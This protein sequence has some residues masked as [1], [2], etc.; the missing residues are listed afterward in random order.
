[1][2]LSYPLIALALLALETTSL[3]CFGNSRCVIN[4]GETK[5][6]TCVGGECI[7]CDANALKCGT[8]SIYNCVDKTDASR[9]LFAHNAYCARICTVDADC[10]TNSI[11]NDGSC[12]V[13]DCTPAPSNKEAALCVQANAISFVGTCQSG[14][15]TTCAASADCGDGYQCI[16]GNCIVNVDCTVDSECDAYAAGTCDMSGGGA[17][18]ICS[19]A[20]E[21]TDNSEC[22]AG[23]YC[24]TSNWVNKC[25]AGCRDDASCTEFYGGQCNTETRECA[26]PSCSLRQDNCPNGN[27]CDPHA[28]KCKAGCKRKGG[29]CVDETQSLSGICNSKHICV[30]KPKKRGSVCAVSIEGD[31]GDNFSC[32]S[33]YD[34][35]IGNCYPIAQPQGKCGGRTHWAP[36]CPEGYVC[37]KG[38]C[39][40]DS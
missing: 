22:A 26:Y 32:I 16:N 9:T 35:D 33:K 27:Y 10:P 30:I 19:Y 15:C 14:R 40:L 18:G 2:L 17:T 5:V 6:G 8:G 23:Q 13:S 24:N 20:N 21:C 38:K 1:M 4:D 39:I 25:F 36:V 37:T 34:L 12:Y 11:C 29:F 7:S 3:A 31:C 28:R